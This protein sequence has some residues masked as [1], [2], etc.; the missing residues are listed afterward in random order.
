MLSVADI[1]D[2]ACKVSRINRDEMTGLGRRR[3][4]VRPRQAI[5][6]LARTHGHT[7]TSIGRRI[8]RDHSTVCHGYDQAEIFLTREPGFRALVD[9]VEIVAFDMAQDRRATIMAHVQSMEAAA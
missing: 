1:I 4:V 9:A 2:A 3:C 5:Y 6:W 7:V 8:N